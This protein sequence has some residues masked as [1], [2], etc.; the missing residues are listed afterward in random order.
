[1]GSDG[2]KLDG[3]L[4]EMFGD[5]EYLDSFT[6]NEIAGWD[7][8]T[9]LDLVT[10]MEETFTIRFEVDEITEMTTIGAIRQILRKRGLQI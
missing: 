1:M 9:H 7:S 5:K 6:A 2:E 3:I 4:K 10:R 8:L